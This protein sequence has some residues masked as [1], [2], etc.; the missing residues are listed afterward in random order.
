MRLA[1]G[2]VGLPGE[3]GSW[4]GGILTC[5]AVNQCLEKKRINTKRNNLGEMMWLMQ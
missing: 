1:A 3:T 2:W 5:T 4:V